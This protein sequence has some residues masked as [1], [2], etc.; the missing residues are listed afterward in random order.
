MTLDPC[1]S[2]NES[3]SRLYTNFEIGEGKFH[4]H[5]KKHI[6]LQSQAIYDDKNNSKNVLH[7]LKDGASDV[8][9]GDIEQVNVQNMF[10]I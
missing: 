10:K 7:I 6:D 9:V 1:P 4:R 8:Q 2:S 3:D 5:S